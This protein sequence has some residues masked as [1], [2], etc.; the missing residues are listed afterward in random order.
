[1]TSTTHHSEPEDETSVRLQK[2]LAQAGVASRRAAEELIAAGRVEVDGRVVR[3]MGVRVDPARAVI[4]VDG[5]RVPTAPGLIHLA[6]NKPAGVL[7][8]MSDARGRPCLADLLPDRAQRL[9]HVGRLD[10]DTEG[11][12]LVT[13]DGPLAHRLAHPSFGVPKTY[14]AEI[15]G[16]VPRELGRVLRA[17]LDLDDGPARADSF[18]VVDAVGRRV[19]VEIVVHEGRNRLVRRMLAQ[20]GH[21]VARL[22][23]TRYGP[24]ELGNLRP[25]RH[26]RLAGSEVTRLYSAVEF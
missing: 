1:L 14:L 7:S 4:R 19:L 9:F 17:G 23:R 25:G 24:V 10:A 3:E 18:R 22:V 12:L 26:R 5:E 16:P 20:V 13:N 6:V 8:A 11:L 2:V 21:P 15:T